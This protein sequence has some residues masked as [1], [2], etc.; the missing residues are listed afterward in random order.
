MNLGQPMPPYSLPQIPIAG[1]VHVSCDDPSNG[2][3]HGLGGL[4]CLLL[5]GNTCRIDGVVPEVSSNLRVLLSQVHPSC[6]CL[7]TIKAMDTCQTYF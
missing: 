2:L 6:K 7:S 5:K 1:S 3:A 4:P